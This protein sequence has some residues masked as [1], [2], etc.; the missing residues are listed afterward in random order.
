MRQ[1]AS[2]Y[3]DPRLLNLSNKQPDITKLGYRFA[4]GRRRLA[5]AA[6]GGKFG[7]ACSRGRMVF[8][9]ARTLVSRVI[10]MCGRILL[11]VLLCTPVLGGCGAIQGPDAAA[12]GWLTRVR[13]QMAQAG[14]EIQADL[15]F[16]E[17]EGL[18]DFAP[19]ALQQVRA[20]RS[21]ING[22]SGITRE[23]FADNNVV[24]DPRK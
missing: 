22:A 5:Q 23:R 18:E 19:N 17:N 11:I 13:R 6:G 4:P 9:R 1:L 7:I 14:R 3:P 15:D 10:A 16:H 21:D 8:L 2:A 24:Q 20:M 12:D